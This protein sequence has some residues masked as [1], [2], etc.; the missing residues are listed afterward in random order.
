MSTSASTSFP[1]LEKKV[2]FASSS[3]KIFLVAR[4]SLVNLCNTIALLLAQML[5]P[6]SVLGSWCVFRALLDL[7]V[8][9][10]TPRKET[11]ERSNKAQ[12]IEAACPLMSTFRTKL[13]RLPVVRRFS[14]IPVRCREAPT[15]SAKKRRRNWAATLGILESA[16]IR[17]TLKL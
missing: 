11:N 17:G 2:L 8:I 6:R 4:S 5:V 3:F 16:I 7:C 13:R 9:H 10:M 12:I 1:C 15:I 14:K